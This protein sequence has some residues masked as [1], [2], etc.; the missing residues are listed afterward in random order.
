MPHHKLIAYGVALQLLQ[1]VREARIRDA[2]LRDHAMRAAKSACLNTA[3]G[4][5]SHADRQGTRLH[6]RARRGVRSG[7]LRRDRCGE[8]RGRRW[9]ARRRD[10][11]R[12]SLRRDDH[13]AD[14]LTRHRA[15]RRWTARSPTQ[16]RQRGSA[17]PRPTTATRNPDPTPTPTRDPDPRPRPAT[18]TP[19]PTPTPNPD[20]RPRPRPATPTPTRDPDPRPRPLI[21]PGCAPAVDA[22][23]AEASARQRPKHALQADG[24][25]QD[26]TGHFVLES[27]GGIGKVPRGPRVTRGRGSRSRVEGR[28]S[29]V[30]ACR[31]SRSKVAGRVADRG[32]ETW[33]SRSTS[34]TVTRARA[35]G[36]DW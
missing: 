23:P 31:G 15:T 34:T 5:R 12:R 28:G 2:Y 16:A 7:G 30:E 6:H 1:A 8:R 36:T 9:R 35:K 14:S 13:A 25:C 33:A 20:P 19:T 18:S 3:E 4:A 10:G 27:A 29:R 17:R 21:P 26:R 22:Q 24:E 32:R 11:L